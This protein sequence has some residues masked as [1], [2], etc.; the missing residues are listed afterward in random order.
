LISPTRPFLIGR[1]WR[2]AVARQAHN[3]KVIGF[4]SYPRFEPRARAE[5]SATKLDFAAGDSERALQARFRVETTT[6]MWSSYCGVQIE[7]NGGSLNF[8]LI[9]AER[10]FSAARAK[11]FASYPLQHGA[12]KVLQPALAVPVA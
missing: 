1:L 10:T 12:R 3:L 7:G 4:K 6:K 2:K 9:K 8:I 11:L 5:C